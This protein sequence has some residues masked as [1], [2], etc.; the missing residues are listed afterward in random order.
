MTTMQSNMNQPPIVTPPK[1]RQKH[2]RLIADC[3]LSLCVGLFWAIVA[4][5]AIAAAFVSVRTI[6]YL[7]QLADTALRGG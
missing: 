1:Q 5:A 2:L 3:V 6:I 4:A 7:A